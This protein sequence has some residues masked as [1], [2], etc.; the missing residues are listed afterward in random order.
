MYGRPRLSARGMAWTA[1]DN[2][3]FATHVGC[4]GPGPGFV[5]PT[6]VLSPSK[7]RPFPQGQG[8]TG[9]GSTDDRNLGWGH[10]RRIAEETGTSR[11]R[12]LA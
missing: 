4:F 7:V 10:Q 2:F 5:D 11:S 8:W 12:H 3:V 1:R 9:A 6:D